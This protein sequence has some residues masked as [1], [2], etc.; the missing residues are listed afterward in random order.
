M[1]SSL[2][3]SPASLNLHAGPGCILFTRRLRALAKDHASPLPSWTSDA[4]SAETQE[5]LVASRCRTAGGLLCKLFD[6]LTN[7]CQVLLPSPFHTHS[8]ARS[9]V[10]QGTI[11]VYH[12]R[13]GRRAFVY[14]GFLP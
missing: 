5:W 9:L 11:N 6:P 13:N 12:S 3:A 7:K 8:T 10:P 2:T 4:A 14:C 1:S